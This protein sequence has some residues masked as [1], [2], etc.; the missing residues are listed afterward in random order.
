MHDDEDVT[1]LQGPLEEIDG[2]LMLRIPLDAGGHAFVDCARG[3][4]HVEGEYLVVVIQDWLAKKLGIR[5]GSIVAV[6]NEAG[7]FNISPV[8]PRPH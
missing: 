3:I 1:S 4:G 8:G 2:R 7:K 5:A 6:E